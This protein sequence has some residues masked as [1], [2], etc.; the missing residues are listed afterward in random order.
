MKRDELGGKNRHLEE[1]INTELR[2]EI[3]DTNFEDG[4]LLINHNLDNAGVRYLRPHN[5]VLQVR[6]G[7]NEN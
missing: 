6:I 3:L 7:E 4:S 1:L 2:L 5:T